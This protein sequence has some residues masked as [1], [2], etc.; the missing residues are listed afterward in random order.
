M[1]TSGIKQTSERIAQ[2]ILNVAEELGTSKLVSVVTDNASNSRGILLLAYTRGMGNC[3]AHVLNL[4]IG[5]IC[6]LKQETLDDARFVV[7]FVRDRGHLLAKFR[8]LQF[9]FKVK[10]GLSVTSTCYY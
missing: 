4:L 1:D 5:D 2:E 10:K 7:N 9:A 6:K 3:A 8:E